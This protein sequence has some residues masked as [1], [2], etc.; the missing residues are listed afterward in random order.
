MP[1]NYA[2]VVDETIRENDDDR[3]VVRAGTQAKT[4]P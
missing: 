3:T 2:D 1:S 4:C